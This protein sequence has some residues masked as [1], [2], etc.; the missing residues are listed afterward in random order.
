MIFTSITFVVFYV[1]VFAIYWWLDKDWQN[2]LIVIAGLIFY[3][4]WDW[5]FAV[6][7]LLTTGID[8]AVGL[9]LEQETDGRRRK[10]WLL[11]S[12]GTNLGVLAG[13]KYFNFFT[14]V[15]AACSDCTRRR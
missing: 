7:L 11:A 1:I 2:R 14:C 5:R 8:F 15:S 3:G 9:A 13:F 4:W 6:L 12:L 10:A